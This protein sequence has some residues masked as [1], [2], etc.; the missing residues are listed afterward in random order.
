MSSFSIPIKQGSGSCLTLSP[1]P[2]IL[3]SKLDAS[4]SIEICVEPRLSGSAR[5]IQKTQLP[6]QRNIIGSEYALG[7]LEARIV[8]VPNHELHEPGFQW[9]YGMGT[10]LGA[11]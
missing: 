9:E 2:R 7:K 8:V 4:I 11:L 6:F 3:I 5:H 1:D 10:K